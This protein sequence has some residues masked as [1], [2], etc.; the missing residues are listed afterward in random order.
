MW[1][2]QYYLSLIDLPEYLYTDLALPATTGNQDSIT[3]S[4][5]EEG[6]LGSDGSLNTDSTQP[7]TVTLT[8][9]LTYGTG[10]AQ[11]EFS[12]T[13]TGGYPYGVFGYMTGTTDLDGSLHLAEVNPEGQVTQLNSGNG[14]LY[15]DLREVAPNHNGAVNT[16]TGL[17]F[18]SAALARQPES[19]YLL[20]VSG[21]WNRIRCGFIPV[22]IWCSTTAAPP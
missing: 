22:P 20:A 16:D 14:V 5:S 1:M 13:V 10:I 3:W 8:A 2:A 11:K 18:T 15:A 7:Q 12:L 9:T 21:P 19:G 6:V 17:Y 4:S